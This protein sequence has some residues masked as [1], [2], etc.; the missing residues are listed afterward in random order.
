MFRKGLQPAIRQRVATTV[1]GKLFTKLDKLLVYAEAKEAELVETDVI[2]KELHD[3]GS[4]AAMQENKNNKKFNKNFNN[5]HDKGNHNNHN[6]ND[7]YKPR[8][9]TN[10][11]FRGTQGGRGDR[12]YP[13]RGGAG[14]R[15]GRG[16]RGYDSRDSR[17]NSSYG[18]GYNTGYQSRDNYPPAPP[19]PPPQQQHQQQRRGSGYARKKIAAL[20]LTYWQRHGPP[21]NHVCT[22]AS[23][24]TYMN[25]E[26]NKH[27]CV[28]CCQGPAWENPNTHRTVDCPHVR[29]FVPPAELME[30]GIG[31]E[32]TQHIVGQRDLICNKRHANV[33]AIGSVK[34]V[35]SVKCAA[36]SFA[37]VP[38]H[39]PM[40]T[41]HDISCMHDSNAFQQLVQY[42]NDKYLHP[43]RSA[44]FVMSVQQ[45]NQFTD[46]LQSMVTVKPYIENQI[47]HTVLF[48]DQPHVTP[49]IGKL[50]SATSQPGADLREHPKAFI[51]PVKFR[52][53]VMLAL[54]DTGATH[55]L[56]S[57]K[58]VAATKMV[59]DYRADVP[60]L[61]A[62]NGSLVQVKGT[63]TDD[64][65]VGK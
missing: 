65:R 17:Y 13:Y 57:S 37:P 53:V 45:S 29:E 15:G 27:S 35:Q 24:R 8:P 9:N 28:V 12:P 51:G 34:A 40:S 42:L 47:N 56:I 2:N 38:M 33:A 1:S 23:A 4:A 32:H 22:I 16:G 10:F 30:Q 36:D 21:H 63:V 5:R 54:F 6:K 26:Q 64:L 41:L 59:K 25:R 14:G 60:A 58:M 46:L 11:K 43:D 50:N 39:Y 52:G 7:Y 55:S 18:R 19:A 20:L 31:R 49:K 3:T 61:Q 44:F 62:A 48:Q